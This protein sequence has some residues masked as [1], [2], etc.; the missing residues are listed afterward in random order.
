M[1]S[2]LIIGGFLGFAFGI[3]FSLTQKESLQACFWHGCLAAFFASLLLPWW[4]RAWR[5]YNLADAASDRQDT[6]NPLLSAS[7]HPKSSKS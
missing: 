2:L 3:T 1:K 7:T 5:K 6:P 4:G